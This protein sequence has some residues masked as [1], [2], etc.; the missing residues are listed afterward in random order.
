MRWLTDGS[1]VPEHVSVFVHNADYSITDT[2]HE[3]TVPAHVLFDDKTSDDC[4]TLSMATPGM[5]VA[6]VSHPGITIEH[7]LVKSGHAWELLHSPP[8]CGDIG[9]LEPLSRDNVRYLQGGGVPEGHVVD[10]SETSRPTGLFGFE[11][12][13]DGD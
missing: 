13:D 6:V 3:L 4:H 1:G 8:R 10:G 2:K 11:V 7:P 12:D 9:K 5:A